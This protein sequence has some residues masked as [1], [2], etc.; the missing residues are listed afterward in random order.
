MEGLEDKCVNPETFSFYV[1]IQYTMEVFSSWLCFKFIFHYKVEYSIY[2]LRSDTWT[3]YAL[4][5]L[6]YIYIYIFIPVFPYF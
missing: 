3:A 1:W 4:D 6:L 2:Q 5:H